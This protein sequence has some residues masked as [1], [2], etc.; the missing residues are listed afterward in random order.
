MSTSR[1]PGSTR[2]R[3]KIL[4]GVGLVLALLASLIAFAPSAFAH[5]AE[6]TGSAECDPATGDY[7]VDWETSSWNPGEPSGIHDD[8]RPRYTTDPGA[9]TNWNSLSGWS[10][11]AFEGEFTEEVT[12][13]GDSFTV[14]GDTTHLR[15]RSVAVGSWASGSG[16]DDI[17][18]TE[19]SLDGDCKQETAPVEPT[20]TPSQ[21]CGV[22]GTFE[23]PDTEGV[24]YLLDGD[25]IEAGIYDGPESGTLTAEAEAGYEL[26][27][28]QWS[29][30]VV[31]PAAIDCTEAT[32]VDPQ[33]S[34]APRCDLPGQVHILSSQ[35]VTYL[36]DGEPIEAGTHDGPISG[37]LTAVADEGFVLED[38]SWS[39]EIDVAGVEPCDD[40]APVAPVVNLSEA[41]EVEGTLVIDDT[42]GVTYFL[43]GDEIAPGTYDGP[44]S[45][46][47]TAVADEGYELTED[48]WS[49][50]VDL[51]A[52]EP[53]DDAA[54]VAPVVN[55]SEACEVEGTLVIDDTEGVTYFLNG[56]EIAPG[57]YDGPR[58][59]TLTAV[60]DEGYELTEAEWSEEVDLPAAEDCPP[61]PP[62]PEDDPVTAASVDYVCDADGSV[63]FSSTDGASDFVVE[64]DGSVV[65]D[66]SLEGEE[67][68]PLTIEGTTSVIVRADG[69]VLVN[70]DVVFEACDDGEVGGIEE[71]APEDETVVEGT[72]EEP[73]A[74]APASLPRTGI[75]A[76]ILAMV[77]AL[78]MGFGATLRAASRRL[79]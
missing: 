47:L 31:L 4:S 20:V 60:A 36:L 59:G 79:R 37:T 76:G 29:F 5:H 35:G 28:S 51:P 34:D 12:S 44:R 78:T 72:D 39:Y 15:I 16:G 9:G 71:E 38:E 24:Q 33:V 32:P 1:A 21:Q 54:P 50:E 53:C 46:T 11:P 13:F 2:P 67:T 7:I 40:A 58:S 57:T 43:D 63:T 6:I 23:I 41:C 17:R 68:L 14:P 77:A 74:P 25:P 52:A 62:P 70:E 10:S 61:P 26:T 18:I 73:P 8:I 45:G 30:P 69:V 27:N 48:E 75:S 22:E 64:V 56:D 3:S 49:E 19:V 65:Y 42:E 55:L 66:Q